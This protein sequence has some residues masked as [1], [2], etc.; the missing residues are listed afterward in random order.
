M[1]LGMGMWIWIMKLGIKLGF[2]EIDVMWVEFV[3]NKLVGLLCDGFV[4][5]WMV[6]EGLWWW[7]VVLLKEGLLVC[8][9]RDGDVEVCEKVINVEDEDWVN[10][11]GL[12]WI[13]WWRRRRKGRFSVPMEV[14]RRTYVWTW[15]RRVLECG[16]YGHHT[17]NRLPIYSHR[18]PKTTARKTIFSY[19]KSATDFENRPP[20]F[21]FFF[22]FFLK[23]KLYKNSR[24]SVTA[25]FKQLPIFPDLEKYFWCQK[26]VTGCE[27]R[28]PIFD[29]FKRK[30]SEI[31]L[32]GT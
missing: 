6:Y 16:I 12:G 19:S 1:K 15:R 3:D 23:K 20:I 26:L 7:V 9:V 27:K 8:E 11:W 32:C 18:L 29:I 25:L 2:G 31:F 17:K 4:V 14:G 24:K 28:L 21:F 13:E 22:F 5:L 10:I 30:I